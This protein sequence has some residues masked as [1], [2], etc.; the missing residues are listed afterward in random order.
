[1]QVIDDNREVAPSIDE[2][3]EHPADYGLPVEIRCG[4]RCFL[5]ADSAS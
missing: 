2:L 5:A 3:R 1:V 4:S